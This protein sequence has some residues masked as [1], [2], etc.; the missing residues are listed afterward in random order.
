MDGS[1]VCNDGSGWWWILSFAFMILHSPPPPPF[2]VQVEKFIAGLCDLNKDQNAFKNHL[3]DFLVQL[4]EFAC[5]DDLELL[6]AEEKEQEVQALHVKRAG[7]WERGNIY[8]LFCF[9]LFCFVLFCFVLFFVYFIFFS[10]L[11]FLF[12]SPLTAIPGMVVANTM[13]EES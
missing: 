10:I 3:R 7:M 13:E 11:I 12:P 4:K 6:F 5:E 1:G 8:F 9:V 2:S